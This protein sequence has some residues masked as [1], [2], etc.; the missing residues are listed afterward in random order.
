MRIFAFWLALSPAL[1]AGTPVEFNRDIR[2]IL[3]DKCF[4]C[5]GPDSG[6]KLPLRL[7]SEAAAKAD[8]GSGRRAIVA[9]HPEQSTLIQRI[10]A[11]KPAMR[12]P[13]AYSGLKLEDHDIATLRQ[14]I[15]EGANWQKHWS[16]IAPKR[17][18]LPA[19]SNKQWP[20]NAIDHFVLARLDREGLKPSPEAAK[21]TLIRRVS[22]DLTGI[23]ATPAEVSAFLA[24]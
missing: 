20:V 6:K 16:L 12:M 24:D 8:L 21:E 7:D 18:E 4:T 10:T 19:V 22:L 23:P 13:P 15:S 11:E 1:V 3:S 5:H 17:P 14:W 2:P 9:G